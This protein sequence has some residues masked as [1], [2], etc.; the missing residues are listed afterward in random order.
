MLLRV[1]DVV[2]ARAVVAVLL[3]VLAEV[4]LARTVVP[5]MRSVRQE[6]AVLKIERVLADHKAMNTF[7]PRNRT[8]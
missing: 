4:V 5:V 7:V 8:D 3:H 1:R 2:L 6:A